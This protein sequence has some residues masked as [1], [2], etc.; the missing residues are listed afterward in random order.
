MSDEYGKRPDYEIAAR[1][2]DIKVG[3]TRWSCRWSVMMNAAHNAHAKYFDLQQKAE[4]RFLLQIDPRLCSKKGAS[5]DELVY[6]EALHELVTPLL[7]LTCLRTELTYLTYLPFLLH[8][9]CI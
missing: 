1:A 2:G 7:T 6:Q 3:R 5:T 9:D 8:S 4:R